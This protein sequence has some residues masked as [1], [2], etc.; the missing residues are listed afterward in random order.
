MRWGAESR[1]SRTRTAPTD[2]PRRASTPFRAVFQAG[3]QNFRHLD[4]SNQRVGDPPTRDLGTP[5]ARRP[6]VLDALRTDF[7][8]GE[9]DRHPEELV[10]SARFNRAIAGPDQKADAAY[11]RGENPVAAGPALAVGPRMPRAPT[12]SAKALPE[13]SSVC[14]IHAGTPP[15]GRE[16]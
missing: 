4:R 11:F 16:A 13:P 10:P 9:H 7:T 3:M 12:P 2:R 8:V 14:S 6:K 5:R 15:A 1:S